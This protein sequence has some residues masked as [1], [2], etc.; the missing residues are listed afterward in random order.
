MGPRSLPSTGLGTHGYRHLEK[1]TVLRMTLAVVPGIFQA[2]GGHGCVCCAEAD[3]VLG[4]ATGREQASPGGGT[5]T[6]D[7]DA[8][9]GAVSPTLGPPSAHSSSPGA[10][11][12]GL[13]WG[14][15]HFHGSNLH[16]PCGAQARGLWAP[17]PHSASGGSSTCHGAPGLSLPPFYCPWLSDLAGLW[18]QRPFSRDP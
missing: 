16:R 10:Q 4:A 13:H 8:N 5:P 18:L 11:L 2:T 6:Q 17:C 1:W 9:H 14:L 12:L 3:E 7:Q 15:D